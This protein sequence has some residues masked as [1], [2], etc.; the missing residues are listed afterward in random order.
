MLLS[1][2]VSFEIRAF[3][4]VFRICIEFLHE[5]EPCFLNFFFAVLMVIAA[6]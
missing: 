1:I 2:Y 3:L 5:F 4:F 6:S